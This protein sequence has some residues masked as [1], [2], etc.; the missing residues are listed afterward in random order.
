MEKDKKQKILFSVLVVIVVFVWARAFK[1]P[2]AQRR[3]RS[4]KGNLNMHA[5]GGESAS[6]LSISQTRRKRTKSAYEEWGRNPFEFPVLK[7]TQ[8]IVLHGILMDVENPR[9][10]VNDVY[11]EKGDKVGKY[12]VVDIQQNKVILNDGSKDIELKLGE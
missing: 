7:K 9:A 4:D 12:T 3:A 11:V 1:D 8:E 2:G 5:E 6:F 10:L